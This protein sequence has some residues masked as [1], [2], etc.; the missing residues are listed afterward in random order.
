MKSEIKSAVIIGIIVVVAIGAIG[1]YF[2][3]LDMS[4]PTSTPIQ[5]NNIQATNETIQPNGNTPTTQP[6]ANTPI[7]LPID[8][9]HNFKAPDLVGISGYINTTPED[10]KNALKNKVVLY[11]FWTYSCINCIRTLPHITAWNEKYADKGLLIIGVHS[12]EFEFEK[13]INN[14][15]FAVQKFGIKYPVVLDSDHQTWAAFGNQYWPREYITDYQGYIRHDHIGEGN[16]DE[17]EKVIQQLLDERSKHLGLNIQTDQSLVNMPE[18]QFSNTQTP[19]LYFGYNFVAG[20]NYLGNSEGFNP[21]QTVTYSLPTPQN[22]DNYYLEGKW[23]NL[24]DSMKLVSDNG[25]IVLSYFAKSVHIVAAN[26][27]TLQ[28]S[29]D[30]NPIRPVDSGD[31]VQNATVHISENR[32]YN[33]VSTSQAGS[34]TLTIAAKPDFQIYTFTF[35]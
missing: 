18:Y 27:S 34:H 21:G 15:K 4:K 32:L 10:L 23:Q 33:I 1:V 31:D 20:R 7:L 9:N 11:D 30:R 26:N 24:P 29:L 17:T 2:N 25:K 13:D 14:V 35:G 12:P 22:R 8:E 28:I 3:S 5:S 16:Y 19:E 6:I